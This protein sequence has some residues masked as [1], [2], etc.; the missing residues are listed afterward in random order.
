MVAHT[1]SPSTREISVSFKLPWSTDQVLRQPGLQIK[2]PVL[3]NKTK[4]NKTKQN[5]TK[6]NKTGNDQEKSLLVSTFANW[7]YSLYRQH[8]WKNVPLPQKPSSVAI[9]FSVRGRD[10]WSPAFP[11]LEFLTSSILHKS[12]AWLHNQCEVRCAPVL[13]IVSL[14][15]CINTLWLLQYFCSLFHNDP[16][17]FGGEMI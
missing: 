9:G 10:T 7:K 12:C 4:R 2:K 5:K 8:I 6:Q 3:K 14:Y 17:A 16:W 13:K 1:F 15:S 11:T